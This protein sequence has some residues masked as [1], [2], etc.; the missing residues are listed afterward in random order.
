[1]GGFGQDGSGDNKV[2]LELPFSANRRCSRSVCLWSVV[3]DPF[4]LPIL[5]PQKI[6]QLLQNQPVNEHRNKDRLEMNHNEQN[7]RI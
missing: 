6:C 2:Y 4:F 1:M 3:V 7:W 5:G